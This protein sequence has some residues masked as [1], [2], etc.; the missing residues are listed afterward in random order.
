MLD[1]SSDRAEGTLRVMKFWT[2]FI[3]LRK[4]KAFTGEYAML[5]N[6]CFL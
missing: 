5:Q 3:P 6:T 2:S 1:F 4:W